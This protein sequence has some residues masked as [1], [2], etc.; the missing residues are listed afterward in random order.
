M[1][2]VTIITKNEEHRIA[3][4]IESVRFA[5]QIVVLDSGSTDA[6]VAIAT[7][8]GAQVEHS[9]HWPGFGPQKNA[10]LSFAIHPWVL[11]IDA[12]EA[13]T[14]PLALQVQAI[15]SRP[16]GA[17]QGYWLKRQSRFCGKLVYF[18][19]W[20]GDR[21]LRL[22]ARVSGRFSD[23]LVHERLL[24]DGPQQTL[25]GILEHDSVDSYADGQQKM[26]RYA[27]LGAQKLA[28]ANRG[29]VGAALVHAFTT[30][31]RGLVFRAGV[32]DGATG[33]KIAWLNSQGAFLKYYW[34]GLARRGKIQLQG[35]IK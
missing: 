2:S 22:F 24:V 19:D 20:R 12:D 6:T 17:T 30:M 10:A 9:G 5:D 13:L 11:S 29:S 21:V 8:L 33:F 7:Q 25:D 16:P 14:N 31:M 15:T 3:R 4:C 28:K 18:G 27:W 34:A 32:L 1:L 26:R 35:E 23:D